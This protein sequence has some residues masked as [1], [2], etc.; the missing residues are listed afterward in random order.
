MRE[1]RK[2][3]TQ[4]QAAVKANISSRKTVAKYERLGQMPSEMKK[5]R[6]YRTREDPFAQDWP[7]VEEKLR[8]SPELEAKTLFEWLQEEKKGK[9]QAGQLRTF[10]RRV[11]DWRALNEEKEAMLEQVHRP[12][13]ALQT[14]GTWLNELGVTINGQPFKHILI[15][16]VLPYS[17]WEWGAIAQSE[18]LLALQR[19]LQSSLLKLGY[20][21]QYHQTD[22]TSAATYQVKGARAGERAYNP[23]YEALLAHFGMTPRRIGIGRP[24]QN[25]D[26]EASNGGLKRAVEQQLLLRGSRD[27]ESLADY[28]AFLGRIMNKRNQ[29]RQKRLAE[30]LAMMKPLKASLLYPYQEVEVKV[31]RGSLIRVQH[32]LYSVPTHLIGQKVRVRLYEWHLEV[33]YRQVQVAHLPRLIGQNKHQVNYR[34][35]IDSLLRKPGG[36][37]QYRYREALFPTLVFQQAWEKLNQWYA[38]RKADLIY[39]RILHL[40]ARYLECEVAEALARL[41]QSEQQWDE[42]AVEEQLQ[43][44]KEVTVPA[45]SPLEINLADYD[46]LLGQ[47]VN[48]ENA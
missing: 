13:E 32:N 29:G 23:E 12:G 38:P 14:D 33:Y 26:V 18:S 17:N 30:E 40:A 24:E 34:H 1:R 11:A 45:L 6:E 37:R 47:G 2:G 9:Y 43:L 48:N 22:N 35:L 44:E 27:F 7:E 10:Q 31:N 15:H 3:R 19:G 20:V 28:E 21:P 16:C 4:E 41:L 8:V 39:L 36:F 46:Q 25:G 42:R 5:E